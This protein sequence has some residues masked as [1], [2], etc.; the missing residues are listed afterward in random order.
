[1]DIIPISMTSLK[2]IPEGARN[3]G[4]VV[5]HGESGHKHVIASGQV[6]VLD[7][8]VAVE[9]KAGTQ[10]MEKFIDVPEDTTI[11]HEEHT[12]LHIP[13]GQYAVVQERELDHI[14]EAERRVMD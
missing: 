3:A 6:L 12:T 9:T 11:S 8:A 13:K 5:M 10:Q 4:K 2:S 14:T 1:M 7:E